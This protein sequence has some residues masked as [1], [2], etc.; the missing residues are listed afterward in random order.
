LADA[1]KSLHQALAVEPEDSA[2]LYLLGSL[3]F[4]QEKYD[5]ALDALS[6]SAKIDP[7]KPQTQYY[8]GKTLIQKGNR[9][10]AETALRRA[11]QL[12]PGWAEAHYLLAVVY[13]TQQPNFKELAQWH[14]QKAIG[15]GHPRNPDLEKWME[16]PK[17]SPINP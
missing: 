11:V 9:G 6:L 3:K 2:S 8:L 7:D 10:P 1:E 5:E 15:G 14:Y 17:P 12:R 16:E 4:R 13:A